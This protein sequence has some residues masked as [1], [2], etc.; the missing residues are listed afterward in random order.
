MGAQWLNGGV[1]GL[2]LKGWGSSLTG[3]TALCHW[4]RHINPSLVLVQPRKTRPYIT[5]R[6]LMEHKNNQIIYFFRICNIFIQQFPHRVGGDWEYTHLSQSCIS[7]RKNN[8]KKRFWSQVFFI[9]NITS[10]YKIC[11][12]GNQWRLWSLQ[13]TQLETVLLSTHNICFGW[14]IKNSIRTL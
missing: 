9:Y 8:D 6:L 7:N 10:I 12:I 4:A 3:V 11:E 1:L 5:E 14:E 2:R 13:D